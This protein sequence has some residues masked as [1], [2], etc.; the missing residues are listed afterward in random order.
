MHCSIAKFIVDAEQCAMGYRMAEGP[1]W[2]DFEEALK[3][4]PDVGPGGHYLG[5]PHTQDNFQ[6][7]FFMPELF[8]NNSIEQWIAEGSQEITARAL[9]HARNLLHDYEEPK[10]DAAKD[11][12]LRDFIARREREIPAADALNQEY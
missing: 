1:K 3:A 11:E 5:H 4:I 10:L 6:T 9:T 2:D 12:E 7:A 8:D